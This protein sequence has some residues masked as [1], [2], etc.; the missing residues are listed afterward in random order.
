MRK[1]RTESVNNSYLYDQFSTNTISTNQHRKFNMRS[2]LGALILSTVILLFQTS[3]AQMG[4]AFTG[5]GIGE[6]TDLG[7]SQFD[8]VTA[9]G[10]SGNRGTTYAKWDRTASAACKGSKYK[11]IKRDWQSAE[12][13]G[14][15]GGIIECNKS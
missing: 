9:G 10:F 15:L 3:C 4:D 2:F 11:I 14:I 12:Y 6:I 1:R 5:Q 7:N 8:I 13:P